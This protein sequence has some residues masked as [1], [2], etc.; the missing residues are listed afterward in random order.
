MK[1]CKTQDVSEKKKRFRIITASIILILV[2]TGTV[3]SF[4]YISNGLKR[5]FMSSESYFK[6]IIK[7]NLSKDADRISLFISSLK[8]NIGLEDQTKEKSLII[9]TEEEISDIIGDFDFYKNIDWL[10][11]AKLDTKLTENNGLL[12]GC[13]DLY[14]NEK[15][16]TSLNCRAD[17][18][19]SYVSMPPI[20]NTLLIT[21]LNNSP[22]KIGKILSVIP[23][24]EILSGIIQ[25]Y[26]NT[27]LENME[28]V[29]KHNTVV[30]I[31]GLTQRCQKFSAKI[32][33]GTLKEILEI[34]KND[35]YIQSA[36]KNYSKSFATAPEFEKL[37]DSFTYM[38]DKYI[39][40]A[41]GSGDNVTVELY[42]NNKGEIVGTG[43]LGKGFTIESLYIK[44]GEKDGL[45]LTIQKAGGKRFT[46]EGGGTV[47]D[48][49]ASGKFTLSMETVEIFNI[50]LQSADINKLSR[51]IFEGEMI[52]VLSE[53][54]RPFLNGVLKQ[55]ADNVRL[56]ITSQSENNRS[57]FKTF[58]Y[59]KDKLCMSVNLLSKSNLKA[60]T[61][62]F[63][64]E[65]MENSIEFSQ[66]V[67]EFNM[68]TLTEKLT[69]AKVPLSNLLMFK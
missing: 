7:Q 16:I 30:K 64:E 58:L 35:H 51:G 23:E 65:A 10:K 56:E 4:S 44:N 46:L 47:K 19:F 27:V 13:A 28:D 38:L 53:N 41:E 48:K 2:A 36:L 55:S 32:D 26:V 29:E 63:S 12:Q 24:Q 57:D 25:R 11:D 20:N 54:V 9:S 3:L 15:H 68:L 59:N 52:I 50:T 21:D 67:K 22:L 1:N 62:I 8:E 31:N 17:D 60:G 33:N 6:H 45:R 39:Q 61:E 69:E 42:V 34:L 18:S 66:W 43:F 14:I 37:N 5:A 40:K 49:T